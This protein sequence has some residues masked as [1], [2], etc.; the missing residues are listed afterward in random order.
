MTADDSYLYYS[1][2]A[3]LER[4]VAISRVPHEGGTPEQILVPGFTYALKGESVY[5]L[6]ALN[7]ATGVLLDRASKNGGTWER[8]RP[9]GA[10]GGF[11]RFQIVGDRYFFDAYSPSDDYNVGVGWTRINVRTGLLDSNDPPV[12][13]L[14]RAVTQISADY[15]WVGTELA[16]YWTDGGSIYSRSVE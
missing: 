5:G 13:V 1:H 15:R 9:L 4:F 2:D 12:R 10:G 3:T 6:E 7:N 14:E 8:I 11:S 16:L